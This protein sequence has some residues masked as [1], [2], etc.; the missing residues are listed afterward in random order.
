MDLERWNLI[1]PAT[2]TRRL[3]LAGGQ[4]MEQAVPEDY[5][6]AGMVMRAIAQREGRELEFI[7]KCY[8]PVVIV[9]SPFTNRSFL[10]E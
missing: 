7:L 4:P 2:A 8:L 10:V 1:V 5:V 6:L 3:H 9:Q